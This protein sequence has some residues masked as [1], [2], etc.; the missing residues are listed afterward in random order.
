VRRL[1]LTIFMWFWLTLAA[2]ALALA[3]GMAHAGYGYRSLIRLTLHDLLLFTVAG[4][5]FCY[6]ISRNLTKPLNRLGDAAA[7]IAEGWLDTRADHPSLVRRHDEISALARNF[8][9]MAERI[10]MLL[11]AERRLLQDISHELRSPLARLSFAAELTRTAEDRDAAV[12]RI[13]KEISRLTNL[14]GALIQVTRAEG[15]PSFHHPEEVQ[16]DELIYE[17][18]ED[19]RT[20]A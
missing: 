14:V 7:K 2:V 17:V 4:A 16:L 20:E 1:F 6:L 12:G 18:V 19:C 13:R 15:D 3:L 11:T 10:E 8:D 9:R 5:I